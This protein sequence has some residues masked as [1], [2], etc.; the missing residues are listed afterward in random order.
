MALRSLRLSLCLLFTLALTTAALA[1]SNHERTQVGH[2]INIAAGDEVSEATCFGCSVRV[3]G[4]VAGDITTFGGSIVVEE[5][6]EVGGDLTAF[7][8]DVRLEKNTKVNGDL[9]VFGGRLRRDPA[10]VIGGD[11]S[12]MGGGAGWLFLIFGLPFVVLGA[13]IALIVWGIRRLFRARVP[14]AAPMA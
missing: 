5:N 6:G 11:V 12:S 10:A 14:A 4:H 1:D 8:G 3:K 13:V 9:A 7:A 2:N